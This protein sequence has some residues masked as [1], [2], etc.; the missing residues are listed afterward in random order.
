MIKFCLYKHL[1]I[2]ILKGIPIRKAMYGFTL[3]IRI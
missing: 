1:Q 3:P 2:Y